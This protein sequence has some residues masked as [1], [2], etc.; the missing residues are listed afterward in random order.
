MLFG[1]RV[2]NDRSSY[3]PGTI[4]PLPNPVNLKDIIQFHPTLFLRSRHDNFLILLLVLLSIHPSH[5]LVSISHVE[6][7][8][9]SLPWV[10]YAE[11]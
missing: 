2:A 6:L 11:E 3:V 9:T 7:V 10:F 4:W 8:E 1:C 5:S